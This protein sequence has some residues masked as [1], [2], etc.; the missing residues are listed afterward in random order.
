M[1]APTP[2]S[3]PWIWSIVFFVAVFASKPSSLIKRSTFSTTTIAS[4]TKRPIANVNANI[5]MTF[6]DIPQA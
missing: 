6:N 4:S 3:A 2:T 1:T 5:I